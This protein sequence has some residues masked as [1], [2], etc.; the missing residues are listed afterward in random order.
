MLI[1]IILFRKFDG[2][3]SSNSSCYTKIFIFQLLDAVFNYPE[4]KHNVLRVNGTGFQQCV[5]PAS[6][7]A[8][9]AGNDVIVLSSPGRK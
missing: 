7:Q 9:T 2:F 6:T 4:G 5:A 3:G 1:K 8:F